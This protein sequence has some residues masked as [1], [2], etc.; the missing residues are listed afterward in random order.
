MLLATDTPCVLLDINLLHQL[1]HKN[2]VNSLTWKCFVNV[3]D[4]GIRESH[5]TG[6]CQMNIFFCQLL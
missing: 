3:C 2:L 1:V 4:T 5:L 6:V